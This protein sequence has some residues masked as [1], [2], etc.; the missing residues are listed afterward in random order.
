MIAI[1]D[2]FGDEM[3]AAGVLLPGFTQ[4][5]FEMFAEEGL[6]SKARHFEYRREQQVLAEA[7]ALSL[8]HRRHLVAEAGTGVGKSLA[9]LAPAIEFALETKQKA[10]ISTHTINLQEQLIYK[11]IPILEKLL[12]V[13]FVAAICKGRQNY[14]CPR[15]LRRAI[16]QTQE[17]FTSPEQMELQEIFLWS[18][19]TTDGT[20]SDLP[21]EPTPHI[22]AQICSETHLCT[23]KTCGPDSGCFYQD[24]RR[25]VASANLVVMNH[26]LFFTLLA[27]GLI[28]EESV[29]TDD[30]SNAPS[31]LLFD[32]DFVIF[33]EA[34]TMEAVAARQLGIGVSQYGL[35]AILWRLYNP[36]TK[37]GL[38]N[39]VRSI[40][41]NQLT[42]RALDN[43]E[44]FFAKI[45]DQVRFRPGSFESRV[46][47]PHFINDCLGLSLQDLEECALDAAR[48]VDDETTR[49]ELTDISRRIISARTAVTT[50]LE[51]DANDY[52]YWIEKAGK[53]ESFYHLNASPIDLAE[54]LESILFRRGSS[55]ITLSATLSVGDDEFGYFRGR[56]G[57]TSDRVD[58]LRVGSP[59]DFEKQ[60]RVYV[61]GAMPEAR[62]PGFQEAM[63][64]EIA[65]YLDLSEGRAFVLFTSYRLM[66][67][68]AESMRDDFFESRGW[69]L[70][71]Q[72]EGMSRRHMIEAFKADRHSVLFGTDSFWTGVDVQGEALSNV[73][74]TQLPF[75]PPDS[76][77]VEA[78][79]EL[80]KSRG[81]DPFREY[82]LPEAILKFRQGIGRLI[83]SKLDEGIVVVLDSR[84]VT[85]SYGQAFLNALPKCP[86][87]IV[88]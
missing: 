74:I 50:F 41:G 67:A 1:R 2:S 71:V 77:G 59:F 73:I 70:F 61:A 63:A 43:M 46:R 25:R 45:E 18:Q 82:S 51:Q 88:R 30:A 72:G 78:R 9:Y 75:T 5:T 52:V 68:I 66:H 33:D 13:E 29:Q 23:P 7:I 38:F 19:K 10:V 62:Q 26:A 24:A 31:G 17:L 65:K 55:V 40:E 6:M 15:R 49:A 39:V 83:R 86:V 58:T 35:R 12:P 22:W 57:A 80:I 34:H 47:E 27:S 53:A 48:S 56:V 87:E 21:R 36:R 76:P 85:K 8:S 14:L 79:C 81:H 11:D 42:S 54:T 84:V 16:Q 37:K 60:M 32:N 20:R 3:T 4:R 28:G 44:T 69:R 64:K